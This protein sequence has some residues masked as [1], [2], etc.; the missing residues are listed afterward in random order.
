M[1][2]NA[3]FDLEGFVRKN[4]GFLILAGV[5]VVIAIMILPS[6]IYT[7]EQREEGVLLTLGKFNRKT[8]AGLHIKLPDPL[9]KVYIVPVQ[10]VLEREFGFRTNQAGV[11]SRR[12]PTGA[13]PQES[14][15]LTG[16]LNIIDVEW[17]IQYN[18]DDP[19]KYLFNVETQ[20]KTIRDVSQSVMNQLVGDFSLFD[21]LR[22]ERSNIQV[23]AKD[24]MNALFEQYGIGVVV[25]SVNINNALPPR[26]EVAEAFQ[27]VNEAV[28]NMN[29]LINEGKEA[30]NNEIPQAQGTS[31]QIVEEA[32]GY[33][34]ERVNKA[35]GDVA[36]FS[37][38]LTEY[39]KSPRV[40]R[41]RLYYEMIEKV[42]SGK[43]GTDLIDRNLDNF[44][45]LKSIQQNQ[46]GAQ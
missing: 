34:T 2:N 26:G 37:S 44:L 43:E 14:T 41:S 8:S 32:R 9:E 15:M 1:A 16:D 10:K 30:Y 46:G 28:Q 38:V 4:T 23:L 17:S 5:I 11:Q 35:R 33:A 27:D 20:D 18:I 3:N 19:K 39:L 24:Q 29:T 13:Y 45:P 12:S 6:M 21:V 42:F 22:Q 31:K 25:S 7:V 36:R 40:T